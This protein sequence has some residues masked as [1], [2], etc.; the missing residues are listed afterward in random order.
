MTRKLKGDLIDA[1]DQLGETRDLVEAA[2]LA[3]NAIGTRR[4]ANA[5]C[6][7]LGVISDQLQLVDGYLEGQLAGRAKATGTGAQNDAA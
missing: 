2:F 6:R 5:L 1:V 4:Q 7:L 3:A